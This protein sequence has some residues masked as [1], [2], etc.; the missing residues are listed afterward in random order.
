MTFRDIVVHVDEK[1]TRAARLALAAQLARL[2]DA[3]LDGVFLRSHFMDNRVFDES[4]AY[5]APLELDTLVKEHETAVAGIADQARMAFEAVAAEVGVRS[6]WQEIDGKDP[7]NLINLARRSDLT[8]LPP[9]VRSAFGQ[10]QVSAAKLGL[11]I[12]GP[13]LVVGENEQRSTIGEH[14]LVA[15]KDTRESARA[16]RDAWPLISRAKAVSVVMVRPAREVGP[17]PQLQRHLEHHGVKAEIIIDDSGDGAAADALCRQ[18]EILGA[19]LIVMGLYG[20]SRFSEFVFGGVTHDLLAR[21][22]APLFMSH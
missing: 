1:K 9:T 14:V 2:H 17:D 8:I 21:P 19:D 20:R 3:D 12:G 22:P 18:V 15:W 4:I 5:M 13:I 7:H 10:S 11:E 6:N 16:L